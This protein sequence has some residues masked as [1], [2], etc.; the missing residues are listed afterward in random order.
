MKENRSFRCEGWRTGS[1]IYVGGLERSGGC[2]L[3]IR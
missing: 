2:H 3:Y 1:E